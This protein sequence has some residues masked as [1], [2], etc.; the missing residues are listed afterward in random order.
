MF[1]LL[2]SI[3]LQPWSRL[4][5]NFLQLVHILADPLLERHY[6]RPLLSIR[7]SIYERTLPSC[8]LT[9]L[10]ED[11]NGR[12]VA[13]WKEG[14]RSWRYVWIDGR[15]GL[16]W[17]GFGRITCVSRSNDILSS[18]LRRHVPC[19][20]ARPETGCEKVRKRGGGRRNSTFWQ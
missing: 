19:A 6:P 2:S 1:R 8:L 15:G 12:F 11:R 14:W 18:S 3:N 9:F 5:P 20:V 16:G 4:H 13:C 10:I 17:L 7:P